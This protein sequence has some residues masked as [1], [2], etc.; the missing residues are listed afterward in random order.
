M[1]LFFMCNVEQNPYLH[2]SL[3]NYGMFL[4]KYGIS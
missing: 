3:L 2:L 4:L 1:C